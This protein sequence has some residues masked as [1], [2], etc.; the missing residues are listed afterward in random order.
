MN[1]FKIFNNKSSQSRKPTN[2]T[3]SDSSEERTSESNQSPKAEDETPVSESKPVTVHNLIMLDE[4][5]SMGAIYEPAL[6]G[7]NETLQTIRAAQDEHPEQT[8]IVHMGTFSTCRMNIIYKNT[9]ARET[10]DVAKDQYRPNGGTPL[11]D[12]MGYAIN[13]LRPIVK[14]DD[15]ALVTIITDGYE[16]ASREFT[17]PAIR[18]LVESL[19][20]EG[21]IFTYIGANQDEVAVAA[22]MAIDNSLGFSADAEGTGAMFERECRSRK[23]FFSKVSK[24]QRKEDLANEDYFGW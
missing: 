22:S 9:P 4:S 1:F 20:K 17:G 16:N 15:I 6:T 18:A 24:G 3:D 13:Q 23:A 10:V 12:A 7:L 2:T 5:G 8:H 21:W 19:K 14:D 11:Y